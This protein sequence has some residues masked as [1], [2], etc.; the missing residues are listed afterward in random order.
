MMYQE[1]I[2]KKETSNSY[3]ERLGDGDFKWNTLKISRANWERDDGDRM[4]RRV[5][6]TKNSKAMKSHGWI[7]VSPKILRGERLSKLG[8]EGA[9]QRVYVGSSKLSKVPMGGRKFWRKRIFEPEDPWSEEWRKFRWRLLKVPMGGRKFR[10][11]LKLSPEDPLSEQA[12]YFRET[13][14]V[15]TYSFQLQKD[16]FWEE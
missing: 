12:W 2:P 10:L 1:A 7:L 11:I 15:L 8:F 5:E 6:N 9:V 4:F 16:I 14:E 13:S 3:I